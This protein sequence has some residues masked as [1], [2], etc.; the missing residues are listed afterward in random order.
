MARNKL[1]DLNDHLFAQIERLTDE[2]LKGEDLQNEITR[3][4]AVA[5]LSDK[6]VQ[7]ARIILDAQKMLGKGEFMPNEFPLILKSTND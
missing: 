4:K 1:I 7:N 5:A 2:D 6:V 3:S